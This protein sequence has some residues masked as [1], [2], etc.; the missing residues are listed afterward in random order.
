MFPALLHRRRKNSIPA[1]GA[2]SSQQRPL[3]AL[4]HAKEAQSWHSISP[5]PEI[6]ATPH[7]R[8]IRSGRCADC[9][10]QDAPEPAAQR[11]SAPPLLKNLPQRPLCPAGSAGNRAVLSRRTGAWGQGLPLDMD[12]HCAALWLLHSGGA[13]GGRRA[14][15]RDADDPQDLRLCM[16]DAYRISCC[17]TGM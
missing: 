13:V 3:Q 10:V 9:A 11:R 16:D 7:S 14:Y 1:E 15:E 2:R 12:D 8:R 6:D 5:A 17:E 4:P